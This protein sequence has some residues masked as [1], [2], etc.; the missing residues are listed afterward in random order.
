MA[1]EDIRGLKVAIL[2]T[3]RFEQVE[4]IEHAR[5]LTMPAP[6]PESCR[7]RRAGARLEFY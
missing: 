1:N 5:R 7:P 3:D 2:V 4:L 6:K